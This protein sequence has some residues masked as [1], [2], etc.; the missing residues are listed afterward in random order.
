[1]KYCLTFFIFNIFSLVYSQCEYSLVELNN[2]TEKATIKSYPF[3]LDLVETPLNGRILLASLIRTGNQYFIELEITEDSSSRNLKPIC[4]ESG[5]RISFLLKNNSTFSLPH[6]NDKICGVRTYDRK[7][8]Y[9][10]VS[11][12]GKFILTPSSFDQLLKSEITL[13][14]IID[15]DFNKSFVIK[16][17]LKEPLDNGY[18]IINPSRFFI[19]NINCMIN[20]KFE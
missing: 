1:M 13:I 9:T 4:L 8:G 20:P 5:S 6:V 11:N 18:R 12:Y 16:N 2:S 15:N 17:E 10:T 14:K 3:T 7:S 19:D